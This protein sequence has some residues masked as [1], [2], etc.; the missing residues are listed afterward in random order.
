MDYICSKCGKRESTTTRQA[1]CECGGL[2]NLD[3]VPPKFSLDDI[4]RDE[5]SMFRYRK[6]MAVEGDGWKDIS[7]GEGMTP[8]VR[9]D[10]NVLLKMDYFMPTLSF[11][12]R[13]AAVLIAH[14]KDIGVDYV[15]QDSS[16]NA[17]NSVAAYSGKAGIK[18]EIFVPEGTSPGKI[19]MICAHGAT[20]TVVPG[21]R[22]HCADVCRGKV[23]TD[24]CYYANHV[25]NPYF[26]E[27]T[28][29]YIYEV[30]EQ[31]KR[32]PKHI[33][34]PVGNGTLFLGA[35]YALE[36]LLASGVIEEMP[37]I[38][39]LQS[40]N[41]DPLLQA[42][43]RGEDKPAKV[44][45]T[46]TIAEGIAIGLPMRGEE[47]LR[48]THKY[49]IKYVHAPEDKIMEARAALAKKG[50]YCE[51]TTAANYAAYLHYCELYGTAE[52]CLITMCGAGLKSDH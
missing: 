48:L 43:E 30:F 31:L 52:D 17:G 45:P 22:D 47:I 33:I 28:K 39:A 7:L 2:W 5:W 36:H 14:C 26:Y 12:D 44:T 8:V 13:G 40:Q 3:Y 21:S 18:C 37:K 42:A 41:C 9:L 51:H 29:T 11:K 35:I 23:D 27:G 10:E 4:D 34:I 15:V 50:I 16:G 25:Y 20:C 49:N 24:G 6:F 32:M 19:D 46:P 38:I 1:K